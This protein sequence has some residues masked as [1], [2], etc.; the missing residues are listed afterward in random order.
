[1]YAALSASP[2]LQFPDS[3]DGSPAAINTN[4][5]RRSF[6]RVSVRPSALSS[7]I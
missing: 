6:E 3:V 5:R 4:A 2:H 7:L 1:V